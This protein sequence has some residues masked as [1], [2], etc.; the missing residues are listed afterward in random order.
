[1]TLPRNLEYGRDVLRVFLARDLKVQYKRSL[2]GLTWSLIN[3]VIQ[4]LVFGFLFKLVLRVETPRYSAYA[5]SGILVWSFFSASIM[6]GT[7]AITNNRELV[8][9]PGFPV[10]LLPITVL[11]S[12]LYHTLVAFPVLVVCLAIEDAPVGWSYLEVVPLLGL[13]FLFTLSLVYLLASVNVLFRDV[14]HIIAV[15]L[16]LLMFISPVFWDRAALPARFAWVFDFNP[17]AHLLQSYRDVL[18]H[19]GTTEWHFLAGLGVVAVAM[20]ALTH[21]W[22]VRMSHRFAEEL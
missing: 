1:M 8:R 13:Q 20:L 5:F 7:Y 16:Q 12:C 21:R 4:L 15:F 19:G 9:Q 17:M 3:P 10:D 18:L 11:V 2:L 14:Q 6:Q 22:F